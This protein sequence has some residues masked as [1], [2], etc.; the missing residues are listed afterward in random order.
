MKFI[1]FLRKIGILRFGFKKAKYHNYK[2]VPYEF[3]S[4]DVFNAK[5]ETIHKSDFKK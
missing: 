2:E 5:K 1:D 4:D 3:M